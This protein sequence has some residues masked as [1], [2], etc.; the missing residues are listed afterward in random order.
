MKQLFLNY[1]R[2]KPCVSSQSALLIIVWDTLMYT[3]INLMRYFAATVYI[4]SHVDHER[5]HS[6]FFDV[7]YCLSFFFYPL[8]GLLADVKPGRYKAIITGVHFSFMSW[9][10]GGLSLIVKSYSDL[11][12]LFLILLGFGYILQVIGYSSFRSNIVQYNIDQLVGASADELSVMIYWES[13]NIP[14]VY[15]V[16]EIAQ[17]LIKQF[18]IVSYIVS[19]LAVS[20][21]IISNI[22]FKNCLDT[23]PHV[24]NPVKLITKVL[25]YA[26]KNKVPQN[27]SA[28][29]YWEVN[30]PTRIDLGKEKYGGPFTEEQV[31]NVK[32]VLRLSPLFVCVVG[33]CCADEIRWNSMSNF[34]QEPQFLPCVI[35]NNTIHFFI[36][37]ILLLLYIVVFYPLFYKHIPSML[38]R[39]GLG[40]LFALSTSLYYVIMFACKEYF[41]FNTTSY[42][43]IVVPQILYG[44]S[45][46]LI[47]STSLEFTIAQSPH[48]MRGL[49]VGLWYAAFGIG[50]IITINGKYPFKCEND[51]ICQNLYYFI[52]KTITIVLIIILFFILAKCYRLRIRENEVNLHVI[53]EEHY[54]RY[55]EQD[56]DHRREIKQSSE[57]SYLS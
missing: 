37:S 45:F 34:K 10:F 30:Y 17:C 5:G 16:I 57:N 47:F 8:F 38:K 36:A 51:I 46:F 1:K 41:H 55:I 32:T 52:F 14:L 29:T 25:N 35:F 22:L 27:R 12:V 42:Q 31:E 26:R 11:D 53:A 20:T 44:I 3:H 2:R 18:M 28:L 49:M 33:L 7:G 13:I 6:I 43:A 9:I 48:E 39:V 19:G 4:D 54:E 40:L 21:V 15:V 23:T 50:Y 56:Q 24:I